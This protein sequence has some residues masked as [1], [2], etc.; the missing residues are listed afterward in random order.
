MTKRLQQYLQT[1]EA[2]V[3]AMRAVLDAADAETGQ[4]S[5]DQQTQYD[6]LAAKLDDTKAAIAREE[7]LI[8]ATRSA[9]VVTGMQDLA[10][11]RPFASLGD[12]LLAIAR[13]MSPRGAFPG[14]GDVDPRL[15]ASAPSGANVGVGSDGGFFV[16]KDFATDLEKAVDGQAALAPRC[17]ETPIGPNSD[18]LEVVTIDETSRATGSRWGGVRVYRRGEAETV[19]ASRPKFGKWEARLEDLMGIAYVTERALQDAPAIASVFAEAFA[20]E[21]AFVLDD[22]IFRGNGVGQCL[23]VFPG[24][25]AAGPSIAVA[26]ES[27]QLSDTIVAENILAMWARVAPKSQTRGVWFVNNECFPQLQQMQ[28]GTGASGQLVYMPPGGLSVAP[29]GTIYGRPVI[30]IEQ[31]SALGDVGDISFLDLTQYKLIR[32]GGVK[33][34]ESIHV[35]FLY[36]ERAFRWVWRVNGAPKPKAPITPYK[37]S[38]TL[39]P[40]VTLAAR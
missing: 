36:N 6:A 9:P 35:R 5:A 1:K 26:K 17:S 3:T 33:Q 34:D 19:A 39:S 12:S 32:K 8:E 31:A 22:E 30:P 23:G 27:G 7:S 10:A 21:A 40:F 13:A 29:H 20:E 4:L 15:L 14:A 25:A 16:G 28:I 18:G 11:D 24:D 37:G 38:K 2:T